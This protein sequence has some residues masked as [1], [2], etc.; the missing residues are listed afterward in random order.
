[1][2]YSAAA[3]DHFVNPRNIGPIPAADGVGQVG[4]PACGASSMCGPACATAGYPGRPSRSGAGI[5][6]CSPAHIAVLLAIA[7]ATG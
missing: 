1:M 7:P 4:G 6:E 2:V 3:R 5:A